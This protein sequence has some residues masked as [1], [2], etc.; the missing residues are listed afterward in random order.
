[1][2]RASQ[3]Y[4]LALAP[5][6]FERVTRAIML[7][8]NKAG[9]L[10]GFGQCI[11][12]W[13]RQWIDGELSAVRFAAARHL[14]RPADQTHQIFVGLGPETTRVFK[15]WRVHLTTISA[16]SITVAT[17]VGALVDLFLDSHD[18]KVLDI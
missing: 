2:K 6:E 5:A 12:T 10:Q 4:L 3:T 15:Q 7:Q 11:A 16:S 8:S 9:K 14:D 1:M 18:N 17:A 13:L